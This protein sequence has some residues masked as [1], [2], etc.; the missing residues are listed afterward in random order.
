M[1]NTIK[2]RLFIAVA[3]F[4]TFSAVL[5]QLFFARQV[6]AN[7]NQE[8]HQATEENCLSEQSDQDQAL[9][10]VE[11]DNATSAANTNTQSHNHNKKL[12][13]KPSKKHHL[14]HFSH[15]NNQDLRETT[16]SA[17]PSPTPEPSTS[18]NTDGCDNDLANAQGSTEDSTNS[19]NE[20]QDPA[21][22]NNSEGASDPADPS[23]NNDPQGEVL[24]TSTLASTGTTE[25]NLESFTLLIGVLSL[26]YGISRYV[27]KTSA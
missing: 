12:T 4:F 11:L 24:G 18:D 21:D 16:S 26:T 5:I 20:S 25:Q 27:K 15:R 3:I 14:K 1:G 2:Y 9:P 8:D 10:D 6:I 13:K 19:T 17:Q 23:D 22:T 7:F